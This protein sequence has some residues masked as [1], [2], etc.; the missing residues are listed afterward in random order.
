MPNISASRSLKPAPAFL[1]RSA[2]ILVVALRDRY[3]VVVLFEEAFI[4]NKGSLF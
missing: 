4:D 2:R 1:S 3:V